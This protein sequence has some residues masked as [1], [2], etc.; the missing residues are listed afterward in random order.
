MK[1]IVKLI[2]FILL[3]VLIVKDLLMLLIF[4]YSFTYFGFITFL[5]K[6]MIAA[7]IYDDLEEKIKKCANIRTI[8]HTSK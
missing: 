4:N 6:V 2:I 7:L 5:F 3:C 8:K 1:N